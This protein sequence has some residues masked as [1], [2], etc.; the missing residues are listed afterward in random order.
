M[1]KINT[2]A[3]ILN[4]ILL[5]LLIASV[6]GFLTF[7]NVYGIFVA[8]VTALIAFGVYKKNTFAYFSAAAWG[9]AAYQLAKEGYEFQ[10][11]KREVM[12]A[13]IFVIPVALFLHEVL[14]KP[15]KKSA[16]KSVKNEIDSDN[17]PQ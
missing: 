1:T 3:K 2:I 7:K 10:A 5:S 9:L 8:S 13:G 15:H 14:G 12:V 16:Q 6:I 17:M 4:W 11:I